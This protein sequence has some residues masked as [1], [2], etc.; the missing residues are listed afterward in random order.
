[1]SLFSFLGGKKQLSTLSEVE[2][3][4]LKIKDIKA[5]IVVIA[6]RIDNRFLRF[7]DEQK[8]EY[9]AALNKSRDYAD[10]SR[11]TAEVV[12]SKAVKA[13]VAGNHQ[14]ALVKYLK[15]IRLLDQKDSGSDEADLLT[16]DM[17]REVGCACDRLAMDQSAM[18]YFTQELAMRKLLLPM[19]G[20]ES[21]GTVYK[22]LGSLYSRKGEY[23]QAMEHHGKAYKVLLLLLGEDHANVMAAFNEW[24]TVSLEYFDKVFEYRLKK[25][26]E[27]CLESLN[28]YSNM[29]IV[30]SY[31]KKNTRAVDCYRKVIS[32]RTNIQGA[33]HPDVHTAQMDLDA[34]LA[35]FQ[36]PD[37]PRRRS[38]SRSSV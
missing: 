8:R 2:K 7:T 15:Y 30:F 28:T 36:G 12:L 17:L 37:V 25:I 24:A 27:N 6:K 29:A 31:Q 16:C 1:M 5:K 3:S 19:D 13:E 23:A 10:M 38:S 32:I 14:D 34:C 33:D 4:T 21:F 20:D 35:Q 22:H 11:E 18:L 9:A 26:G